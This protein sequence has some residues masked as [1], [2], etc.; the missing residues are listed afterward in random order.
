MISAIRRPAYN[1]GVNGPTPAE[2]QTLVQLLSRTRWAAL[3]TA[4]EDEPLASWVAVV[5]D[6]EGGCFLLHLSHLAQ[7]TRYLLANPRASLGF[8]EPDRDPAR[9]PQTLA[10]V[11]LQGRVVEIPRAHADYVPGRARYLA[12]LPE[13]SVQF[14]LADFYLMR[15]EPESARFV[16]GFG[17]VHRLNID[18]LRA[19]P[20]DA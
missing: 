18:T 20:T 2:Q 1:G 11:S 17:R 14:G 9:D 7:H 6:A 8:T 4:R 19:L 13:A 15:F 5:P 12:T 3:A 16:P 10:R